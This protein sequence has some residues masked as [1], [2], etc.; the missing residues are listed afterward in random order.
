MPITQLEMEASSVG[1]SNLHYAIL[2]SD[3][4]GGAPAYGPSKALPGSI[5][6][7]FTP[8]SN[9]ATQYADNQQVASVT[10]LGD[11]SV[12]LELTGMPKAAEADFYGH[13]Y[14]NGVMTR[15]ASDKPNQIALMFE[16][17][18]ADGNRHLYVIYKCIPQLAA[19]TA[20]TKANGAVAFGTRQ[21]TLN[22]APRVSDGAWASDIKEG[23]D[24]VTPETLAAFYDA[25]I[26]P[27]VAA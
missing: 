12:T 14:T 25:P 24:G 20:A 16:D 1:V 8:S 26:A 21:I 23:D 9:T 15:R 3:P 5:N 6:I 13:T 22:A 19:K 18:D 7:G 2:L 4:A 11:I 10:T 27:A 17:L